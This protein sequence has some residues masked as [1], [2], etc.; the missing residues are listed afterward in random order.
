MYHNND[1]FYPHEEINAEEK[2]YINSR[3]SIHTQANI[4]KFLK[5]LEIPDFSFYHFYFYPLFTDLYENTKI[6]SDRENQWKHALFDEKNYS[7]ENSLYNLLGNQSN[8]YNAESNNINIGVAISGGGYRSMLTGAGVLL[9]MDRYGLLSCTNYITAVSGGSWLLTSLLLND[10]NSIGNWNF[11]DSLLEGIPNI[12]ISSSDDDT[13][14]LKL[15]ETGGEKREKDS[16]GIFH[17]R[18]FNDYIMFLKLK[19]DKLFGNKNKKKD[20]KLNEETPLFTYSNTTDINTLMKMMDKMNRFRKSVKFYNKIHDLVKPK[21]M[22]GFPLSFTDYW[23]KALMNRMTAQWDDSSVDKQQNIELT[24]VLSKSSR[25]L[26]YEIPLPIIVANCKNGLLR[27]A[28]F[29]FTPFEFGS[30]LKTFNMFA[31][32]KYL[33]SKVN[34]ET[35]YGTECYNGFDNIGFI[36]ATSSSLFNI[37]FSYIW[38]LT[39]NVSSDTHRA[40]KAIF[41]VFGINLLDNHVFSDDVES[42]AVS[43]PDYAIFKTNPFY[44]LNI[45]SSFMADSLTKDESLYL[46]DGGEDTE[47]LP[48]R[49][50][51]QPDRNLDIIFIVDSSSDRNNFPNGRNLYNIYK[52]FLMEEN[53]RIIRPMSEYYKQSGDDEVQF[54]KILN[55]PKIPKTI[56]LDG[57]NN[58]NLFAYNKTSIIFGCFIESYVTLPLNITRTNGTEFNYIDIKPQKYPPMLLYM[59]NNNI[60]YASNK[61]T[62]KMSYSATEV[63]KMIENGENIFT[64]SFDANYKKCLGCFMIKRTYDNRAHIDKQKIPDFCNECYKEYCYN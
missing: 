64:Q 51:L 17:K 48:I 38:K 30:W 34:P 59:P 57:H 8:N 45:S 61:S 12:E 62:F 46:V 47:N 15:L 27:N 60:S 5:S 44:K 41:A 43:R 32:I 25:F 58:T 26:R 29:E 36:T 10:F 9:G 16:N 21:K 1:F 54:V 31:N 39:M 42:S 23:S 19:I 55:I 35:W 14:L 56:S 37:L 24:T 40:I 2:D 7:K 4:L 63:K 11:K 18:G 49:P 33:G 22:A 28:V 53:Y 20:N 13:S 52:N 3:N 6:G 50:L